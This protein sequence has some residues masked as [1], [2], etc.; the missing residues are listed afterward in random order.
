MNT[1]NFWLTVLVLFL[2]CTAVNYP[3]HM[4][5]L[6]WTTF[7]GSIPADEL[8]SGTMIFNLLANL[9]FVYFF[10]FVFTKGYENKGIAEGVRFGLFIGLLFQLPNLIYFYA[11]FHY[12]STLLWGNFIGTMILYIILG[13]VAAAMYKPAE[14]TA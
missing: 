3:L 1:K 10:L 2:V 14:K 13:I 12:P 8:G 7:P 6:D 4:M 11:N 5:I 9:I